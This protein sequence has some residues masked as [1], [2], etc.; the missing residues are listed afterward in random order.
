MGTDGDALFRQ[1]RFALFWTARVC[2][3][4]AFQMTAVAV[5]WQIYALTGS[6]FALGMVGLAQF[7]PMLA[8]IFVAGHVA[9]QADRSVI[10][11]TCLAVEA[12]AAVT[13]A[14]GSAGN[15]LAPAVIYAVV[16]LI[17]AART[18]ESPTLAAL[19]PSLVTAEQFPRATALSASALQTATIL[20]PALGGALFAVS[21][22][23]VFVLIA[24]LYVTGSV[25]AALIRG[26]TLARREKLT[27]DTLFAG[28]HFIRRERIVL[29]AISLDLF[30]VLLGGATALLPVY[31][32]EILHSGPWGLG[33]LRSAPAIGALSMSLALARRPLRRRAGPIMFIAVAVFGAATCVFGLSRWLPLSFVALMVAGGADVVSVVVRAAVVQLGTPDAMRGRV[34]AVNA[35]FIG[36]SNQ[37]GEFES[38]VTASLLG[39]VPSVVAGGI[40]TILVAL[41]W[42]RRFPEL[43]EV[44]DLATLSRT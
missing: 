28:V 27:L 19:L 42:W 18:F 22:T 41:L 2:S 11:R 4:L 9:D 35:L 38:G 24:I 31:A 32:R 10:L 43:R 30:A 33:L 25:A 40:G 21:P 13:L 29:G 44:D 20:G 26:D 17:G 5:G 36:T 16:A 3:S 6:T 7:L 37:L 12:A 34:S 14:F 39:T 8:L 1:P 15:W 23:L